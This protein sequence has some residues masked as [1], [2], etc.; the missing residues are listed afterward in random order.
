MQVG[1][2]ACFALDAPSDFAC[3]SRSC[4]VTFTWSRLSPV[5]VPVGITGSTT[6]RNTKES[7]STVSP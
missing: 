5:H 1:S 4:L 7:A 3:V 6:A 2:R